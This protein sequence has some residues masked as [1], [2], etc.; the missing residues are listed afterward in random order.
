MNGIC[1]AAFRQE[2]SP[3]AC[4]AALAAL[5]EDVAEGRFFVVELPWRKVLG[6]ASELSAHHTPQLGTRA[7]DVI[8]AGA[9]LALS[10]RSFVTYDERQAALAKAVGLRVVRP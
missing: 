8:H 9:A 6:M 10:S 5:S 2:I 7:L 4:D 1:L 3:A